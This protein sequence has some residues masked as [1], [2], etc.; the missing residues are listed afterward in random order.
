MQWGEEGE[1]TLLSYQHFLIG[2]AKITNE[3]QYTIDEN[4]FFD[5]KNGPIWSDG[6]NSH[7]K[8]ENR[9]KK[10]KV[11]DVVHDMVMCGAKI[12]VDN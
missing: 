1:K 5:F 10:K 7:P 8:W 3:S 9:I 6:Q 4:K 12:V 2:L 11:D